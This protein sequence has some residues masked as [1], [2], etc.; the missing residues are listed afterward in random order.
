MTRN[1]R[2]LTGRHVLMM[3]VAFFGVII[4][5]NITMAVLANT[6]WTGLIAKNGYVASI[7]FAKHERERRIAEALGWSV[8]IQSHGGVVQVALSDTDGLGVEAAAAATAKRVLD[9]DAAPMVLQPNGAGRWSATTA[10]GPG[11][12]VVMVE[13]IDEDKAHTA[14]Q[15]I[16]IP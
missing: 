16:H 3:A 9:D 12:W 10:L 15:A 11:D 14:R 8:D 7:D 6:S 5:V 2:E 1:E 13:F 4:T